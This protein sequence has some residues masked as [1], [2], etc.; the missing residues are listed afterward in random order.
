MNRALV[1]E[2]FKTYTDAY[3]SSDPKIALKIEH[4]YHVAE[5]ADRIARSLMSGPS[6]DQYPAPDSLTQDDIDLAWLLGMLH[7]IGRFEQIRRY[8]T[9]ND[10]RSI[11][12][13]R[14]SCE[15]L[16]PERYSVDAHFF[17][18]MP[19]GRFGRLEDYL[20]EL[21]TRP[22]ADKC[23]DLINTAI[24]LHSAFRLPDN[25][26]DRER[27]FCNI[28]RD[29]DKVDILRVN[30]QT[31]LTDIINCTQEEIRTASISDRVMKAV[32]DHHAVLRTRDFVLSPADHVA[33]HCCLA[34]ELVYPESRRLAL[35]QGYLSQLASFRNDNEE[36]NY[37][38]A[39]LR[40]E[41]GISG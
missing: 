14:M 38:M 4:T 17:S 27:L 12:H 33:A 34:F 40:K 18:E 28:L 1:K 26:T 20:P 16:F 9:F 19:N 11:P 39:I 7:D 23:R 29:A 30:V 10:A 5:N 13:A 31:P 22:D 36:T 37:R 25:L 21:D 15:V 41:L 32:L 2:T 35:Q 8:E 6:S 24:S 3:N